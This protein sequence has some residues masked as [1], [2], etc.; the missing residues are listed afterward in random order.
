MGDIGQEIPQQAADGFLT[1]DVAQDQDGAGFAA[2]RWAHA[3]AG[4]GQ[5]DRPAVAHL[6]DDLL[7]AAWIGQ[8]LAESPFAVEERKYLVNR[9]GKHVLLLPAGNLFSAMTEKGD[10]LIAIQ[11]DDAFNDRLEQVIG[12]GLLIAQLADGV[13][14]GCPGIVQNIGQQ[15]QLAHGGFHRNRGGQVSMAQVLGGISELLQG[16]ADLPGAQDAQTRTQQDD[17]EDTPTDDPVEP[18]ADL[19]E[20]GGRQ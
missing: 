2:F 14:Q 6:D 4:D 16:S 3:G 15:G 8:T 19:D 5:G 20:S 11:G 13:V 18:L 7:L 9:P 10:V 17:Q 1:A 12:P